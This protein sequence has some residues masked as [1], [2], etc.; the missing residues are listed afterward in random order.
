MNP[1]VAR[2]DY[3]SA[4]HTRVELARRDDLARVLDQRDQYV[5]GAIPQ[6]QR[7]AIALEFTRGWRQTEWTKG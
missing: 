7:H 2:P 3:Q 4:P 6:M 5:E 1:E